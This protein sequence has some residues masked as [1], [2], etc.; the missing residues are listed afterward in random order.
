MQ[1]RH[2]ILC[3][4]MS[5]VCLL[6]PAMAC[7][8]FVTLRTG[9]TIQGTILVQND[10]V[11]IIRDTNG[12]RYQFPTADVQSIRATAPEVTTTTET[13]TTT[14]TTTKTQTQT[15]TQ[16]K[17]TATQD[18]EVKKTTFLIEMAGGA[19]S[20]PHDQTGGSY[21]VDMIIGS[22]QIAGR[23][24][25]LGGQIGYHGGILPA[26]K[27]EAMRSYH[28]LPIALAFRMPMLQGTHSPLVGASLGYG[29][30]LS[31]NYVGGI[32]TELLL[33][34]RYRANRGNTIFAGA[35]V[36]FQQARITATE[37]ELY[38]AQTGRNMVSAG[39]KFAFSF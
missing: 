16:T 11:L 4:W 32:Y 20:I 8:E 15:K 10:E 29:I 24:V 1:N 19:Y 21:S 6:W 23:E 3:V 35:D 37:Y 5:I 30:G 13:E 2:L 31:K 12:Q 14:T 38:T 33:G 34:Y 18:E 27:N 36:Q 7:A 9:K 39:V 28:F 26:H 17:T 22:R 25:L